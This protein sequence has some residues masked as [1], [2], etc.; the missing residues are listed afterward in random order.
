[1]YKHGTHY[2]F[3]ESLLRSILPIGRGLFLKLAFK[4][5]KEYPKE[6]K[7]TRVDIDRRVVK[8]IQEW[9]NDGVEYCDC[10][11]DHKG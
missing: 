11:Y 7:Q 5:A 10:R 6:C 4:A 9:K 8:I 2:V 3:P 1:M